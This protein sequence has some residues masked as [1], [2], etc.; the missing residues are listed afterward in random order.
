MRS[1]RKIHCLTSEFHDFFSEFHDFTRKRI[2]HESRGNECDIGFSIGVVLIGREPLLCLEF[3][4]SFR[5]NVSEIN[6]FNKFYF[7][8]QSQ[9]NC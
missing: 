6:L 8:A 5:Q 7:L 2:L 1:C 9:N 3:N 4:K